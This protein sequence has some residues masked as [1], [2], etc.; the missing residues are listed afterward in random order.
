MGNLLLIIIATVL[1]TVLYPINF[2]YVNFIKEPFK[3]KRLT[4]FFRSDAVNI[5]RFG[6]YS[7]RGLLNATLRK[8]WGYEFGNFNE[9]ISSV[10]GK[11]ERDGTL[12]RAGKLLVWVLGMIDKDHCRKSIAD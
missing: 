8:P 6:N 12:S 3:W 10:L 1:Y 5:D 9:T 4:G 11:N 2:V 7:F